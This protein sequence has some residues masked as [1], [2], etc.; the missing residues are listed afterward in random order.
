MLV[1]VKNLTKNVISCDAGQIGPYQSVTVSWG[2][3]QMFAASSGLKS[4]ETQGLITVTTQGDQDHD[5]LLD[6]AT[7]MLTSSVVGPSNAATTSALT[8]WVD[9]TLG[10]DTNNSGLVS[11]SPFKTIGKAMDSIPL[12]V[13][14]QCTINVR[15]GT[16]AETI[17]DNHVYTPNGTL[18]GTGINIFGYDLVTPTL[19]SGGSTTGTLGTAPSSG[20]TWNATIVTP[21]VAHELKG[22]FIMLTSGTLSGKLYPIADNATNTLDIPT[23]STSINSVTFNIVTL[24]TTITKGSGQTASLVVSGTN[25]F[26]KIGLT[27]QRLNFN[28]SDFI[29]VYVATG[30][31][32]MVECFADSGTASA[33]QLSTGWCNFSLFRSYV[34]NAH[35]GNTAIKSDTTGQVTFGGSVID[36][37]GTGASF[38]ANVAHL[39]FGS[40]GHFVVQGTTVSGLT[41]KY[42][43]L[44]TESFSSQKLIVRNNTGVGVILESNFHGNGQNWEIT[45]NTSHGIYMKSAGESLGHNSLN[46]INSTISTNGGDGISCESS[47]NAIQL[48][49][50]TISNNTGVGVNLIQLNGRMPSSHNSVFF[51]ST[52]T[53]ASNGHDMSVDGT[54][55][56]TIANL[57]AQGAKF[58]TDAASLHNRL[59]AQ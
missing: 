11:T 12:I 18:T 36:G 20:C 32:Q 35:A 10:S 53:M 42:G 14:H 3:A 55:F 5:P 17:L 57:R 40:D 24:G 38:N 50:C 8:Y 37:G 16:V 9:P 19:G 51:D 23:Y 29:S 21:W 45:G 27:V 52:C 4:L 25:G 28:N 58:L 15:A 34:N 30:T 13:R 39:S 44:A 33:I 59:S 41:F 48:V 46:L 2:S 49:G 26:T 7:L 56:S 6:P 54:N 1:T 22:K 43:P 47:H 31:L